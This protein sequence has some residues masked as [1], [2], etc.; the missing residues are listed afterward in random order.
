VGKRQLPPNCEQGQVQSWT[1]AWEYN[2]PEQ[3]DD[4]QAEKHF[5]KFVDGANGESPGGDVA[6]LTGSN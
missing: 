4:E 1:S 2:K 6:R 3:R 5:L